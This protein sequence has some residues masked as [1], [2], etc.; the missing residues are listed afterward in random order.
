MFD[1]LAPL[2]SANWFTAILFLLIGIAFL[3][4]GSELTV[5][6]LS[7]IAKFFGV[8]EIVVTILGISVMSSLPEFTVSF[9]ANLQGN[10]DISIGNI[11]GSNFVTLTFVTALCALIRPMQIHTDIKDRES[12]W[13]IL[14]TVIIF[15]LA[16]DGELGRLDGI[17]LILLYI[18]YL[19]SVINSARKSAHED[20]ELLAN[21][22][23]DKKI[24]LHIVFAALGVLGVIA[25]AN[26][27]LLAGQDIGTRIGITPL[28]MGVLIFAFGTSL[29]ELSVALSATFKHK[30]E[31]SIGEVYASN[32]FTAMFVLGMCAL[33]QPMPVST[34][35]LNFDI[36]F[37]ILAGSVIQIF[38]TTGSKLQRIEA[39]FVLGMYVYFTIGHFVKVPFFS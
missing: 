37:L 8:R 12:A 25:G 5:R 24:A 32:I 31:V 11:I 38:V 7:P 39:I 22:G 4:G 27:T 1:F 13:M 15:I 34:S 17:V 26:I 23:K 28:A 2:I 20:K 6:K 30:A 19:I 29:P 18:P 3:W 33:A 9:F 14:S 21:K 16:R 10:P 35:I 36:P